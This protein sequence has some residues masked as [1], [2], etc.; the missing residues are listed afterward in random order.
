MLATLSI[1]FTT[2]AQNSTVLDTKQQQQVSTAL[3]HDAE[4]MSNTQ[5]EQLLVGKR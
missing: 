5:L 2:M 3:E 4:I 1:A